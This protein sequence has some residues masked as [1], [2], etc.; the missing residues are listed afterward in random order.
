MPEI[1]SLG[2][3]LIDFVSTRHGVDLKNAPGFFKRA[4]GA[5]ANMAFGL[6]RLGVEVG[7]LGKVG[8]DQFG[9]FLA[10]E[11]N[12]AG[13]DLSQLRFTAEANTTLA[14]VSLTE[15]GERDFTFYRDPGADE[16]LA[17]EEIDRDYVDS[18][19]LLHFGSLS[20]THPDS[21]EATFQAIEYAKQS[22][23]TVSMDPNL[24]PSLWDDEDKMKEAALEGLQRTDLVKLNGEELCL[25]ADSD[26]LKKAANILLK[27]GPRLVVVTLGEH[28]S[29]YCH[30]DG[31][32]EVPG[33]EVEVQDTT[34]AG[35][36]FTAGFFTCL[37][38]DGSL[39]ELGNMR[40]ETLRKALRFGNAVAALTTTD[41]GA[42]EAFPA[43]EELESFLG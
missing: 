24:R 12:E 40:D 30:A 29:F 2:E 17:A 39:G 43:R 19:A 27:K 7:F 14:F 1:I 36:G 18:A 28:G 21:R 6:A 23:L 22:G 4:G 25:L 42:T 11:L 31:Y 35:D 9:H 20:L 26:S 5:P 41:R 13:V 15:S 32:D 33:F 3:S 10:E 16:L 37:A 34:G 8:E 38:E